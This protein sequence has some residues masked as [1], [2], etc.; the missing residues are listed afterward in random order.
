MTKEDKKKIERMARAHGLEDFKWIQPKSLLLDTGLG[1]NV[2][3]A[4]RVMEKKPVVRQNF[5]LFPSAKSFLQNTNP[6]YYSIFP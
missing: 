1:Q 4:V 6:G 3:M 5:L 2:I